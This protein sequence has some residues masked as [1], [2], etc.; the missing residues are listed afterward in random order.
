MLSTFHRH[1]DFV[2]QA[3][4]QVH[5]T[6]QA[7]TV[8]GPA[9]R[10]Q[11]PG[12]LQAQDAGVIGSLANWSGGGGLYFAGAR[13]RRRRRSSLEVTPRCSRV[14]GGDAGGP[15]EWENRYPADEAGSGGERGCRTHAGNRPATRYSC[16]RQP[17]QQRSRSRLRAPT[18]ANR[19]VIATAA[20]R[21]GPSRQ[22]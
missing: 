20:Q 12:R 6:H 4:R 19:R 2:S 10:S 8:Q 16:R 7:R 1:L 5:M 11:R 17:P 14:G 3:T 22:W 13:T 9:E 15:R 21:H 18:A